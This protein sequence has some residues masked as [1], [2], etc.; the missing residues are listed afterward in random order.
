MG[1]LWFEKRSKAGAV[2]LGLNLLKRASVDD[3][4]GRDLRRGLGEVGWTLFHRKLDPDFAWQKAFPTKKRG[5][6]SRSDEESKK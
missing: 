3:E 4:V 6:Q 5:P 1:D 2:K